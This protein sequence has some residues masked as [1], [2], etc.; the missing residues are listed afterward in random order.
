M[1]ENM[2]HHLLVLWLVLK[3][4][5]MSTQTRDIKLPPSN[6]HDLRDQYKELFLATTSRQIALSPKSIASQAYE[7]RPAG[8][9]SRPVG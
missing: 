2:G 1:V 7:L 4:V 8:K 5:E 9:W 6:E 3:G